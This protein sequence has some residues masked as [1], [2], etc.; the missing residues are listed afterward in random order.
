MG[1]R[2]EFGGLFEDERF[3]ALFRSF[4]RG[5]ADSEGRGG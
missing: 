1:R 3:R 2:T 4:V 5:I